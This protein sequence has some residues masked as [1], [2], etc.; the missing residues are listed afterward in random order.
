MQKILKI[1]IV[2]ATLAVLAL[3]GTFTFVTIQ[4]LK[5]GGKIGKYIT[6]EYDGTTFEISD[7][8]GEIVRQIAKQRAIYNWGGLM[9]N[10]YNEIKDID[11]FLSMTVKEA[12]D[13]RSTSN[14]INP[15]IKTPD[16]N[17]PGMFISYGRDQE[18]INKDET[19]KLEDAHISIVIFPLN[20]HTVFTMD[21]LKIDSENTT[22]E[23]FIKH[24]GDVAKPRAAKNDR[25]GKNAIYMH[26]KNRYIYI[27]FTGEKHTFQAIEISDSNLY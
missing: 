7:T 4:N 22:S 10:K 21:G 6:I 23:D 13:K 5:A 17:A 8:Y 16:S 27:S 14:P 12:A 3:M 25:E 26:Y 11:K 24:F 20:Q 1:I 15:V 19:T 2:V 18:D 9:D